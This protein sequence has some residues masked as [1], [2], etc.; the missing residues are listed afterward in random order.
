MVDNTFIIPDIKEDPIFP[1][2]NNTFLKAPEEGVQLLDDNWLTNNSTKNSLDVLSNNALHRD[3]LAERLISPRESLGIL[4]ISAIDLGNESEAIWGFKSPVVEKPM[5]GSLP[6]ILIANTKEPANSTISLTLEQNRAFLSTYAKKISTSCN[7]SS[8]P[9]VEADSDTSQISPIAVTDPLNNA[10]RVSEN[11]RSVSSRATNRPQNITEDLIKIKHRIRSLPGMLQAN[12]CSNEALNVVKNVRANSSIAEG[13]LNLDDSIFIKAE[14]GQN[15]NGSI[16]EISFNDERYLLDSTPQP[17]WAADFDS[18]TN[19]SE[20][21]AQIYGNDDIAKM[22]DKMFGTQPTN[23][24][25]RVKLIKDTKREIVSPID[26][27]FSQ[28]GPKVGCQSSISEDCFDNSNRLNPVPDQKNI[29]VIIKNL[30]D[31]INEN[32]YLSNSQKEDGHHILA[33]LFNLLS[34]HGDQDSGNS[35]ATEEKFGESD[36][37]TENGES[38]Q[39]CSKPKSPYVKFQ[40]ELVNSKPL[41]KSVRNSEGKKTISNSVP[42]SSSN[43]V[44][45]GPLK[46]PK[47]RSKFQPL[48]ATLPVQNMVRNHIVPIS[49]TSNKN[50]QVTPDRKR[51]SSTPTQE[52]KLRKPMAAST[53]TGK[54]T[55]LASIIVKPSSPSLIAGR[56]STTSS[57]TIPGNKKSNVSLSNCEVSIFVRNNSLGENQLKPLKDKRD[58][59][60]PAFKRSSIGEGSKVKN[61]LSRVRE[62]LLNSPH[63]KGPFED[64]ANSGT[65]VPQKTKAEKENMT[66]TY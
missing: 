12:T 15:Q 39:P 50:V 63:F 55:K 3:S 20:M 14:C 51:L 18:S 60:I 41:N 66:P 9:S 25:D 42:S 7:V 44:V 43:N 4:N 29:S 45:S 31:I 28:P 24:Q 21:K 34:N 52:P 47:T 56:A 49:V 2:L 65:K 46:R 22:I 36:D 23:L 11:I 16:S 30:S 64:V 10:F 1:S 17:E 13:G 33:Q 40:R 61:V 26:L 62:N 37:R 58:S 54:E 38:K 6:H 32:E 27:C 53:P 48:R 59:G 19:S 57:K 8:D 5:N 35:S